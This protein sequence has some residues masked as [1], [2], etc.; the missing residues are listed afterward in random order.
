MQKRNLKAFALA[1]LA[2]GFSMATY[3]TTSGFYLGLM[4]GYAQNDAKN[5]NAAVQGLVNG[6]PVTTVVKPRGQMFGT[7]P[8]LGYQTNDY[9]AFELGF[10]YFTNISYNQIDQTV[11]LCGSPSIGV[12]SVEVLGKGILPFY[13]FDIFFKA[14]LAAIYMNE[15]AVLNPINGAFYP[16]QYRNHPCG[17]SKNLVTYD[18]VLAIGASYNITPNWVTD[19]T[20]SSYLVGGKVNRINWLA[21]GI[22]YHWVDLFCGQFLC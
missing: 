22:S 13:Y 15:S 5:V 6:L 16:V 7:R 21:L 17:K 2:S 20:L 12:R 1:L 3:A 11:F 9:A 10:T 18:P 14:G 4:A 19:L 8:Y